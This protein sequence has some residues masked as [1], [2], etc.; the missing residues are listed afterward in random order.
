MNP[1]QEVKDRL[2]DPFIFN[3]PSFSS[4]NFLQNEVSISVRSDIA[5]L[6][7]LLK[8]LWELKNKPSENH[9]HPLETIAE[10]KFKETTKR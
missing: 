2:I 7:N 4:K 3:E 1:L 6:D 9:M 10:E 5:Q 8:G